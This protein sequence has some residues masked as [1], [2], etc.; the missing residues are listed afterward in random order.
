[1]TPDASAAAAALASAPSSSPATPWCGLPKPKRLPKSKHYDNELSWIHAERARLAA[2]LEEVDIFCQVDAKSIAVLDD[3]IAVLKKEAEAQAGAA[4]SDAEQKSL[5]EEAA[6]ATDETEGLEPNTS[7]PTTITGLF[8]LTYELMNGAGVWPRVNEDLQGAWLLVTCHNSSGLSCKYHS[9]QYSQLYHTISLCQLEQT[10]RELALESMNTT[11]T[12]GSRLG[13]IRAYLED[14]FNTDD[15][16]CHRE[17]ARLSERIE[18]VTKLCRED[19]DSINTMNNDIAK[20][21]QQGAE[22]AFGVSSEDFLQENLSAAAKGGAEA[23][24]VAPTFEVRNC[25]TGFRMTKTD[26]LV[27]SAKRKILGN[28]E[29]DEYFAL[30][31]APTDTT[32]AF[33]GRTVKFMASHAKAVFQYP[34]P[35]PSLDYNRPSTTHLESG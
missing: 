1:M 5:E 17:R 18:L 22:E 14:A 34:E 24:G 6:A 32:T 23:E 3:E 29:G 26:I 20:L 8:S 9:Y 21:K 4:A 11:A 30:R 27:L 10:K 19:A 16:K 15:L 12:T 25:M 7:N 33:D 13:D 28:S 31:Q 2:C 35:V